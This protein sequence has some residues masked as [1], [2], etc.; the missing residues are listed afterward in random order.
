MSDIK[1]QKFRRYTPFLMNIHDKMYISSRCID[2]CAKKAA[3]NREE[4][5]FSQN[6][7]R[8]RNKFFWAEYFQTP[9]ATRNIQEVAHVFWSKKN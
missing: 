6:A 1:I 7:R 5:R 2:R 9:I 4:I 3:K 8:G